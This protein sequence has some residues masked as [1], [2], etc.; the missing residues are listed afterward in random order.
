MMEMEL[1]RFI[2]HRT[3]AGD[4][5]QYKWFFVYICVMLTAIVALLLRG[6]LG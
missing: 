5:V 4:I 6:G 3:K 1:G 2:Q